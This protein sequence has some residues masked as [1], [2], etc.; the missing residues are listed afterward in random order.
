L[1]YTRC[2]PKREK[3]E[4]LERKG[5]EEPFFEKKVEAENL[6]SAAFRAWGKSASPLWNF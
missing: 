6:F 4:N 3:R 2:I 1:G 5:V